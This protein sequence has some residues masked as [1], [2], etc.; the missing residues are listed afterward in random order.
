MYFH[1]NAITRDSKIHSKKRW[2]N[3]TIKFLLDFTLGLWN[4]QC[5]K[6]HR[7]TKKE[8]KKKKKLK[9]VE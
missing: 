8:N 1:Q 6:L 4:E 5:D 9:M 2:M 3:N 7:V